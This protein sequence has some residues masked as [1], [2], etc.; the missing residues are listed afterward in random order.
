MVVGRMTPADYAAAVQ[1]IVKQ[2]KEKFGQCWIQKKWR[3]FWVTEF[4][5]CR[6]IPSWLG[7][8]NTM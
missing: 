4:Q 1:L 3:H 6:W 2:M 7:V 5:V 8:V